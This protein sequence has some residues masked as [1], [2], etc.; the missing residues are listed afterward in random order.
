MKNTFISFV[1]FCTLFGVKITA[2]S[3][4]D[5]TEIYFQN[6]DYD[7]VLKFVS[8]SGDY[9]S[10][11]EKGNQLFQ[12]NDYENSIKFLLKAIEIGENLINQEQTEINYTLIGASYF[13]LNDFKNAITYFS[14]SLELG[15]D[16]MFENEK[17]LRHKFIGDSFVELVNFEN[18]EKQY[19]KAIKLN[20]IYSKE[21]FDSLNALHN[22]YLLTKDFETIEEQAL[23]WVSESLKYKGNQS[24]EY[25]VAIENVSLFY[26]SNDKYNLAEEFCIKKINIYKSVYGEN[27]IDYLNAKMQLVNLYVRQG[28]LIEAEKTNIQLLDS[29]IEYFGESSLEVAISY[30]SLATIYQELKKYE[31]AELNFLKAIN[32]IKENFGE[33]NNYYALVSANLGVFYLTIN[34]NNDAEFYLKKSLEVKE[35]LD[36]LADKS[37]LYFNLGA[38]YQ[39][40]DRCN[41]AEAYGLKSI[42]SLN[43]GVGESFRLKLLGL[44]ITYNCLKN[45]QKEYEYLMMVSD[46]FLNKINEIISY[47]TNYEIKEYLEKYLHE[48]I[49]PLSFIYRNPNEFDLIRISSFEEE[50]MMKNLLLHNQNRVKN[51]IKNSDN[52]LLK[53]EY[54]RFI[55]Y[56]K[57]ISIL[58]EIPKANRPLFYD[59]LIQDTENIE[60][61]LVQQSNE[62]SKSKNTFS[63]R[64]DEFSSNL[65]SNELI[66][67]LVDFTYYDTNKIPDS[68]VYSAFAIGKNYIAPKF[69]SLFEEKELIFLLTRNNSQKES[70]HIDKQYTD[71]AISDLFLKPLS[72]ELEEITTIYIVPSGLGHQIDFAALPFS[73]NKTL[74]EAFKVHL[75]GSSSSLI[76]YDSTVFKQQQDLEF[77][78]Y[79]DI[80]YD[81]QSAISTEENNIVNS[82]V[83]DDFM[84]LVSR[85]GINTWGYLA[86]T[87]KEVS[88]IKKQS[89]A[90]GYATRI[91]NGTQA[92]KSSILQLDGKTTP[93]VLHLATHGYFFENPKILEDNNLNITKASYYKASE[94]PMLRS[95][96]IFAGV[97]TYWGKPIKSSVIDDGILTAKEISNLDLSACQLV[98]LSACETGLGDINGSEGVF[99]LQRAFKIAGVKNIIMSLWKVPDEQTAELFELFYGYC[100]QGESIHEALRMAQAEMK[101]KYSPYYWAGFVLLE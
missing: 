39:N 99:G 46:L 79:G 6:R 59:D 56:K 37:I 50:L 84:E 76:N 96:L 35:T 11:I 40:L 90:N 22:L 83:E 80:D 33:L 3:N 27:S 7:K 75:L 73:G 70:L 88:I 17:I 58:N 18:A 100:F 68:L 64:W 57:Q 51:S 44:A 26:L 45:S 1:F 82:E 10:L 52:I 85:S 74:G 25:L 67:N 69:I 71:E 86:G 43:N 24:D 89:D 19:Y 30:N 8:K 95:G 61:Y 65:K 97:N 81:K 93:Y 48:R 29:Y 87:E 94:D 13:Q 92:T 63:I 12:E 23:S 9:Q 54:E 55:D 2:Q 77:L 15:K 20:T 49:Y 14:K 21:Y 16:Y 62:F 4:I 34:K 36:P 78:L 28:E 47:Q 41:E 101:L 72:K 38:L 98:V 91:I 31:L 66:I 42:E 60:K 5:S 53:S 32:I